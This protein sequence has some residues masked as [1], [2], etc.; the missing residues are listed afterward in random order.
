MGVVF[1]KGCEFLL[2][3]LGEGFRIRFRWVVGGGFPV[4][5]EEK[6]GRGTGN[7]PGKSMRTRLSK[8]KSL[9]NYPLVSSRNVGTF[10]SG[11]AGQN[12]SGFNHH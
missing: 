5:N 9:V 11:I 8:L 1:A 10:H 7:G 3:C 2:V 6:G 4:E 12:Y